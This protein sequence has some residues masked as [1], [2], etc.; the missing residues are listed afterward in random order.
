[1]KFSIIVTV[2]NVEKYICECVDSI[3]R[4][5]F[6]DY[7]VILVESESNDASGKIC[8]DYEKK[9]PDKIRVLHQ[10]DQGLSYARNEGVKIASG[11]YILFVDGDDWIG[12]SK[13]LGR[14]SAIADGADMISY[15]WKEKVSLKKDRIRG[16]LN[17]LQKKYDSGA[18]Y[19]Q[20]ALAQDPKYAWY[21]WRYA[22][23]RKFWVEKGFHYRTGIAY[24]DIDLTYRVLLKAGNISVLSDDF[25]YCYRLR[26]SSMSNTVNPKIYKDAVRIIAKNIKDLKKRD[27]CSSTLKKKL[28]NNFSCQYFAILILASRITDQESRKEML[29]FLEHYRWIMRYTKEKKQML[30]RLLVKMFGISATVHM[31]GIRR[32]C[33]Q[34]LK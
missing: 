16:N 34:C 17:R 30:V 22:Y 11:E 20:A 6:E 19:L 12:S 10:K 5:E 1:M 18:A 28:A 31:L 29:A 8:D 14:I 4:Q 27:D 33:V 15:A 24:E 3:L 26:K 7:E 32:V 23:R 9:C 21:A 13:A 2:F 25:V